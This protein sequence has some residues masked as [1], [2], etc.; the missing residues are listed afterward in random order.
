M[1]VTFAFATLLAVWTSSIL[2]APTPQYG[3]GFISNSTGTTSEVASATSS[4]PSSHQTGGE[5]YVI[6]FNNSVPTPPHVAEVLSRIELSPDHSDVKYTFNNS[7]FRG[8]VANMKSHCI[9]ALNNM[10]DVSHVEKSVSIASY[11]TTTRS[12]SPWG[13]QRVSS[14][15]TVSGDEKTLDFTYSFNDAKL[16]QGVDIYIVDTGV[17]TT[18]A[19]FGGRAK[20]GFSFETD[21]SD[22]D[23][24]GTH[25]AGTAAGAVFGVASGASIWA[26][27][28]LGSDGSGASSD[29][30]AGMNWVVQNHEARKSQPGFVG[31]IMSMSW[32]LAGTS[33]AIDAAIKSALSAGIHVSVAAGNSG[34]DACSFSPSDNGGGNSAA[35]S[36]GSI[37][38][39]N[40]V[41]SF[42]NTGKCV[43]I[44]APGENVL[45]AWKDSDTTIQYLSGTSMATPHVTG[46][47]AYLMAQDASLAA[48]PAKLKSTLLSS[49]LQNIVTGNV[50][51]GDQKVL[52]NNGVTASVP[53]ITR[54]WV[55]SGS[56]LTEEL[57][58]KE[59]RGVNLNSLASWISDLVGKD[60]VE[61]LKFAVKRGETALRY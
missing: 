12:G 25:V 51:A 54:R 57:V 4:A 37:G 16:G 11:T 18:H 42:S 15:S 24:H 53:S 7:A 17:R 41:S 45:S 33:S 8:F 32:G 40:A 22:G 49:A 44:Y 13:L 34:K 26:V 55:K 60:E 35:V 20:Q 38:I 52:L 46:V 1:R 36:V 48:D 14:A 27:K 58:H 31:S 21:T 10:T 28:V 5:E 50:I 61:R 39:G 43:D 19:V 9:D 3:H 2:A 30:I 23:G 47:M 56:N 6:I 29:T 59:K